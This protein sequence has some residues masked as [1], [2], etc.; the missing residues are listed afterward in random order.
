MRF[1]VLGE[2]QAYAADG[3][4]LP[5]AGGRLRALLVLLLLDAGRTVAPQRL[6]DGVYGDRPPEQATNALQSQ[7]SRLRRLLPGAPVEF[8]P[9]GYRLAV[10]PQRVDVHRFAGLAA[11]GR[12]ALAAGDPAAAAALLRDALGLWRGEPLADVTDAPF[13]D[14]EAA[15]LRQARLAAVEDRVEAE[16]A[17]APAGAPLIAE[18]RDLVAANPLRERLHGQLMR[19]LHGAG[20]RAEA[21]AA[22]A[23]ARRVLAEELGTDPSAELATLHTALLRDDAAPPARLPSPLTSF[24]GREPELRRVHDLLGAARLVTL[25]GP[26]GAGKTRLATT[27]AS[28]HDGPVCLVELAAVAPGAP[29]APAVLAALD[30]RDAGLRTPGGPA[31]LTDRL[32]AALADRRLLLVLDN[33]EHVIDD[34][35]RLTGALLAAAPGLRVLATSREPLGLTG[36]AL[37]PVGGLPAPDGPAAPETAAGYPAVRLFTDR[38]ADV[39][40]GF[41]LDAVT[42]PAVLRI[43]RT[44]DGLP[45]ALELAAAR[46][47]ALPVTQVAARLDDRFRLLRRG[48]RTAA[49]RHRTLEAVVGWSWDL[50]DAPERRLAARM[51]VFAGAAD[52]AA[53]Q[54]VCAPDAGDVVDV[55]TGLVDKSLVEAT[56][57]RYRML[58]TIREFASAR[59]AEGGGTGRIRDA[60]AA[61]FLDLALTGDAA[62][63]G[64]GQDR[65]LRRLDA[66]RDDLH[67]ALRHAD[68]ATGLR[69]VAA[70]AFYWWLRGM[71]G[72]GAALARRLVDRLDGPPGGLAEEYALALLVATLAGGGDRSEVDAAA[73]ILWTLARPPRHP[74]LLYLSGMA[75]GPPS[76]QDAAAL[77]EQAVRDRLIGADP[78]SRAL[79]LLGTA[80]VSLL[81]HRHAQARTDLDAALAGFRALD[82]RWGMIVTLSTRAEAAYRAG[83]VASAATPMAEALDLAEQLGS[84][85]DLAELLR[86]R[87]DGRLAAGDLTGAAEDYRRVRR[88][89]GP[90]GAPELVAAAYLGLSEIARRDGDPQRARALC[91]RAVADCP[92]GWFGA[93][94]VRLAALVTLGQLADAA[95]DTTRAHACYRQVL[96][97]DDG[98][99]DAP[100]VAAAVD[101]LAG[102]LLRDG[103]HESAAR[104]L[105]AAAALLA[106]TAA[107]DAPAGTPAAATLRER[108]GEAAFTTAYA[109]GADLP[110]Q[111]ALA[112]LD[113]R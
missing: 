71:R 85:L 42:T 62:L 65:W 51:S 17:L 5:V 72:E 48:D 84:T 75:S 29:V 109:R 2:T 37:C 108:L 41:T 55:L 13:A 61:Y 25:H 89:A 21:L 95:G 49:P 44:L 3:S 19:A 6:V 59:L 39:S 94:V 66:A 7:V 97:A 53:V 31:D 60:H 87:A 91:E 27:V 111:R 57:G 34:A 88:I 76:P 16:L 63:R 40:P 38:A 23:D 98:V 92:T 101:G 64:G 107:A 24:V 102:P 106:G 26:G 50:L 70:L 14:A 52:L 96:T 36:E 93:E 68:T 73:R 56:G 99:W 1:G 46:L 100:V 12:A 104:L 11:A 81:H 9:A 77:H 74:F 83:D 103:D 10:D 54:A 35:A 82:D 45:L 32:V 33:C 105:G 20:R 110:R 86:T 112:L 113:G 22:Y 18:L 4:L 8:G 78:W 58:E 15:R 30:L 90:A 79:G 67:A 43:C 28:G 69:L 47:R 80:M